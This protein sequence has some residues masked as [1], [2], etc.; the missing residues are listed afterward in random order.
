MAALPSLDKPITEYVPRRAYN[1]HI[2]VGDLQA[3]PNI[4]NW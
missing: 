4:P 3:L 2:I 1:C